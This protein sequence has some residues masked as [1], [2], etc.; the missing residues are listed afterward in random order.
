MAGVGGQKLSQLPVWSLLGPVRDCDRVDGEDGEADWLPHGV[1]GP[2]LPRAGL[3]ARCRRFL[4]S[5]YSSNSPQL[6]P[7]PRVEHLAPHRCLADEGVGPSRSRLGHPPAKPSRAQRKGA[8]LDGAPRSCEWGSI[9][10]FQG[11]VPRC[12]PVTT[13]LLFGKPAWPSTVVHCCR[14]L[15]G[16]G[17]CGL[18]DN[19][20]GGSRFGYQ[21]GPFHSV[22]NTCLPS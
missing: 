3:G 22:K 5:Q 19:T 8:L 2:H 13:F 16:F 10:P 4:G 7:C 17:M 15:C 20:G 1:V 18:L 12:H 6:H 11:V 14:V 21:V 9:L